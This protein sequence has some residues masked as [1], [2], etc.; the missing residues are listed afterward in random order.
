MFFCQFFQAKVSKF[1]GVFNFFL[2]NLAESILFIY[3]STLASLWNTF[4]RTNIYFLNALRKWK[5]EELRNFAA[6]LFQFYPFCVDDK[7]SPFI[8]NEIVMQTY[9]LI[10]IQLE[11]KKPYNNNFQHLLKLPRDKNH[12]SHRKDKK[13]P[14]RGDTYEWSI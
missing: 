11:T 9:T 6:F 4:K 1:K 8:I 5:G 10:Y 14:S 3:L 7:L 13:T 2:P 12:F